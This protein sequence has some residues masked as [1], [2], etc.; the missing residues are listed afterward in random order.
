MDTNAA[1]N[2]VK[3]MVVI[4]LA[5]ICKKLAESSIVPDNLRAEA[6]RFVEEFESLLPA[7]GKGTP[8]EHAQGETLLVKMA[9]FLPRV[10]EIQSWPADSSG[11]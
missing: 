11:L 1:R 8:A 10:I 6:R 3:V 2:E 7:R 5:A 4:D 9:R